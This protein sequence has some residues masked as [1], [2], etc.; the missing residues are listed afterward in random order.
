MLF[1]NRAR[2][3]L[4]FKRNDDSYYQ[5]LNLSGQRPMQEVREILDTWYDKFPEFQN[6]QWLSRFRSNKEP[7]HLAAFFEI[8]CRALLDSSFR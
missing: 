2:N 3:D 5:F 8:Y 4:R 7:D 1:N 6:Q